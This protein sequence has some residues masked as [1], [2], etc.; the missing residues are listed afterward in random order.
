MSRRGEAE[1]LRSPAKGTSAEVEGSNPLLGLHRTGAGLSPWHC[2]ARGERY[3]GRAD[4]LSLSGGQGF[5]C[6]ALALRKM[7]GRI[8]V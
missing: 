1:S 3:C 6:R 5:G 2:R 7:R 4:Q 8:V